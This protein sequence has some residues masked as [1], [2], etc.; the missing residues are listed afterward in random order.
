MSGKSGEKVAP[1]DHSVNKY[2]MTTRYMSIDQSSLEITELINRRNLTF[3]LRIA[4]QEWEKY[5]TN[6]YREKGIKDL[7]I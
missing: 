7:N 3:D 6:G 1:W 2:Y 4:L 5:N